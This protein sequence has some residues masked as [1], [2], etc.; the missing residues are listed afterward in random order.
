M[1]RIYL[2]QSYEI[3]DGWICIIQC[4]EGK[5]LSN[6]SKLTQI[7]AKS[8]FRLMAGII[9]QFYDLNFCDNFQIDQISYFVKKYYNVNFNLKPLDFVRV[10]RSF[11]EEALAIYKKYNFNYNGKDPMLNLDERI[12]FSN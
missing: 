2:N 12:F 10:S 7:S 3:T 6:P 4:V 9:D 5:H 1:R 8:I 11:F